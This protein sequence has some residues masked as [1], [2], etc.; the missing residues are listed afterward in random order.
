[1]NEKWQQWA[2]SIHFMDEQFAW[3]ISKWNSS[4]DWK[5]SGCLPI[6]SNSI[7]GLLSMRLGSSSLISSSFPLPSF[8]PSILP[9]LHFIFLSPSIYPPIPSVHPPIHPSFFFSSSFPHPSIH[10]FIHPSSSSSSSSSLW[11]W[12]RW[13]WACCGCFVLLYAIK[14]MAGFYHLQ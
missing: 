4:I 12:R 11:V 6:P 10:P 5:D 2:S 14:K 9:P 3:N 1:M 7:H 13:S 8:H